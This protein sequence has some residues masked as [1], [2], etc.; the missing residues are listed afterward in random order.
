MKKCRNERFKEMK[1]GRID[2]REK[3]NKSIYVELKEMCIMEELEK[4]KNGKMKK[5]KE[6]IYKKC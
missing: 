4:K 6:V 3:E 1:K 2:M 5:R